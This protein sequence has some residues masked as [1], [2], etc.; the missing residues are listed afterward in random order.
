MN[1]KAI[2]AAATLATAS[3][4]ANAGEVFEVPSF[5]VGQ[6]HVAS[7]V[8]TAISA[9]NETVFEIRYD[10]GATRQ[11]DA[12]PMRDLGTSYIA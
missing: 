12:E 1:V 5:D 4:A 11:A 3:F 10:S 9:N 6:S 8:S 7:D 2:L